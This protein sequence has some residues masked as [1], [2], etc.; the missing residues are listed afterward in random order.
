MPSTGRHC[1]HPPE[2][3]KSSIDGF[4]LLVTK[5]Y[6]HQIRDKDIGI[7]SV[8]KKPIPNFFTQNVEGHQPSMALMRRTN[9]RPTLIEMLADWHKIQPND[10]TD[11]LVLET[12][13]RAR[14][15]W[16]PFVL[17]TTSAN[18]SST[19]VD[20]ALYL[21]PRSTIFTEDNSINVVGT[22]R[23]RKLLIVI[24]CLRV[25]KMHGFRQVSR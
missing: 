10:L 15:L 7:I 23:N 12:L 20:F 11:A 13:Q 6:G 22:S 9:N 24:A 19:T 1:E 14:Y 18:A 21:W 2:H 5:Q 25:M 16:E 3:W 8:Y 17:V 4:L